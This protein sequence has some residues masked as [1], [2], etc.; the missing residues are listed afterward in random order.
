MRITS[1]FLPR[2]KTLPSTTYRAVTVT[3][4][5]PPPLFHALAAQTPKSV[6]VTMSLHQA[7]KAQLYYGGETAVLW[8]AFFERSV[9][10]EPEHVLLL[11]ELWY[12]LEGY[13]KVQGARRVVTYQQDP[14]FDE[15]F[16]R[17]FLQEREFA[18]DAKLQALTGSTRQCGQNVITYRASP[19]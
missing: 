8:E 13:L 17:K 9:R 1:P 15:V 14:G 7:G 4:V 5:L 16:Y 19:C 3:R 18:S 2:R 6:G 10:G 11:H 12:A